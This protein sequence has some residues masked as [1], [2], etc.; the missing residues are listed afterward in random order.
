M[1]V[2]VYLLMIIVIIYGCLVVYIVDVCPVSV[3]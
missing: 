1:V 3:F 2:F